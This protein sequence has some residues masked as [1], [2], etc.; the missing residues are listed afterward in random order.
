MQPRASDYFEAAIITEAPEADKEPSLC[1][2]S[3][4]KSRA[5]YFLICPKK[6]EKLMN[7]STF[8]RV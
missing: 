1:D 2:V 5:K 4:W 8:F 6:P 3:F 7:H